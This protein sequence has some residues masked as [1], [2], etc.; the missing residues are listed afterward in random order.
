[1]GAVSRP[2]S[3]GLRPHG[4]E[5]G[6][7]GR[8]RKGMATPGHV[9]ACPFHRHGDMPRAAAGNGNRDVGQRGALRAGKTRDATGHPLE[10]IPIGAPQCIK[11]FPE[12]AGVRAPTDPRVPARRI[13]R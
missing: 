11:G 9:A 1:M 12:H 5:W 8:A 2:R 4:P 10:A 3:R 6:H 13:V 7:E